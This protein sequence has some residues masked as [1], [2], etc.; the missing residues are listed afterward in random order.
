MLELLQYTFFRNALLAAL[1][2]AIS[3][4]IIGTYIVARRMVFI[5][6]GITHASFG[7]I[8]I[9]YFLGINP[10][11]GAA[12][13]AVL[14]AFGI[15]YFS[16][17]GNIRQDSSIAIWWSLGMAVGIVFIALTPGYSPNL[18][19]FLFGSILTVTTA[20]LI[21]MASLSVVISVL[22]LLFFRLIMM[23]SFDEE[24]AKARNLPVKFFNYLL[25]ALS[26]LVIVASIRVSGVILVLSLLTLPQATANLFTKKFSS[27]MVSSILIGFIGM[28][29]GLV[30]S[31]YTNLPSGATIILVL[32]AFFGI[33]KLGV[34]LLRLRKNTGNLVG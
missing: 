9:A 30:V 14:S 27:I 6:G 16:Q 15:N 33:G 20:D 22:F 11:F 8:G 2:S 17:S 24:F 34:S 4:G 25:M 5:G 19:S 26:S 10:I 3:C 31:Y 32:T 28:V 12:V 23:I 29:T 18:M 13:F 7:G 1:L 21:Y